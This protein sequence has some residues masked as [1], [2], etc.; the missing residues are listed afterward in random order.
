MLYRGILEYQRDT[1]AVREDE[2]RDGETEILTT[3]MIVGSEEEYFTHPIS[4][5]VG[6]AFIFFLWLF[7]QVMINEK[8]PPDD[9]HTA[10]EEAGS[11]PYYDR[12]Q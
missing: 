3:T 9:C 5:R 6:I 7:S 1:V 12:G 11:E 2:L 10:D 4:N 8:R